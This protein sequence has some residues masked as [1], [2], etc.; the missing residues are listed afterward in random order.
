[1]KKIFTILI[2]LFAFLAILAK[3]VKADNIDY[4]EDDY[5]VLSTDDINTM[6]QMSQEAVDN[7]DTALYFRV[8]DNEV[9]SQDINAF[10]ENYYAEN[11]FNQNGALF[12][13]D[14]G[15]ENSYYGFYFSGNATSMASKQSDLESSVL[16]YLQNAD[17][18][19][20]YVIYHDTLLDGLTTE[21]TEPTEEPLVS[22]APYVVDNANKLSSSE[23]EQ[24]TAKAQ[25]ISENYGCGIYVRIYPDA[26]GYGD[27][28]EGFSEYIYKKENLGLGTEKTG[29]MF[30]I[31][32]DGRNYDICAYG[33]Q[34]HY[35]FTDYGKGQIADAVVGYLSDGDY[36]T[37]FDRYMDYCDQY[38]QAEANGDPIDTWIPDVP[39]LTPEE[40]EAAK[41]DTSGIA[42]IF[43]GPITS[44]LICLGL[45]AKNK[46]E[47]IAT[48][49]HNYIAK[50]GVKLTTR[51]DIFI[52][53]T[54][55]R[56]KIT[57]DSG[58]GGGHSGGT[59]I[60]SGGFSHSSGKF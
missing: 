15:E 31:E 33:D 48:E 40:E 18:Y 1:M 32:F 44:L 38:L 51:H 11:D 42:S 53:R 2:A 16:P 8:L 5:G 27:D 59:S 47:H 34:A 4:V 36:Y 30:I 55:S 39:Q 14:I 54:V 10:M 28:I 24:L 22:N 45:R 13:I 46:T 25:R 7:Y 57:R 58:G 6:T 19:N 12:L 37:G 43:S 21:V 41:R 50:N 60:S 52:N 35:A 56:T 9:G 17:F 3:P 20:A 49:A 26:Q 29:V 23:I